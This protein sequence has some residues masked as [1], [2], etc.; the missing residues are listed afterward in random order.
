[1]KKPKIGLTSFIFY[2]ENP[3]K[4]TTNAR[5][6]QGILDAGGIPVL[7]PVT[8]NLEDCKA[9][10]DMV[11]GLLIPGGEDVAPE[12]Y[13]EDPV[14]QVNYIN[15]TKDLFD[16]ELIRLAQEQKK[17]IFGICRG[18][19]VLNVALGGSLYQDIPSQLPKAI[20][21]LQSSDLRFVGTH[22]VTLEPQSMIG[23]VLGAEVMANSYHHQC[24]KQLA[25][26][27]RCVGK[28][29]DGVVEAVETED[30]SIFAV[31]WHPE[32][33]YREEPVFAGLFRK[34]IELSG[35]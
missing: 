34:L 28:T 24:V 23:Q 32:E 22:K 15:R 2:S 5:Y 6:V 18:L 4:F 29:S 12:F 17:P 11:D 3:R 19:Q 27:L 25:E 31:Q 13:G 35:K 26:P 9:Y 14:P 8:E 33:M 1:M 30:G 20:C 7:I 10:L 16:M 21:H